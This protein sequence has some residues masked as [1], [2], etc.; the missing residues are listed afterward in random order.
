LNDLQ[1]KDIFNLSEL[2]AKED[3]VEERFDL[4]DFDPS[5]DAVIFWSSGST[6]TLVFFYYKNGKL[7][8]W[9]IFQGFSKTAPLIK[10]LKLD[11]Y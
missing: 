8:L 1:E 3:V 9:R 5:D 6:G 11:L 4:G 2:I 10:T 7:T